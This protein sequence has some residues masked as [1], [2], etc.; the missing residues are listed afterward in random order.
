[1]D[2]HPEFAKYPGAPENGRVASTTFTG[3]GNKQ[4][5]C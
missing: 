3:V 1:M 4:P 5:G 2:I